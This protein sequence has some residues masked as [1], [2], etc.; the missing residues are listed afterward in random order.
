MNTM[1]FAGGSE[2]FW[3]DMSVIPSR[4]R[5]DAAVFSNRN[6]ELGKHLQPTKPIEKMRIHLIH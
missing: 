5:I 4:P 6:A 2:G 3:S 1:R